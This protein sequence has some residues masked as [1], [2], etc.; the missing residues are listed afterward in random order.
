VN[1]HNY[2]SFENVKIL[3]VLAKSSLG[4]E[5]AV[6]DKFGKTPLDYA[7]LQKSG[8]LAAALGQMIG[9]TSKVKK[10]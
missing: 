4:F 7:C 3:N 6:A 9:A 10:L 8:V 5:L 2:G 1:P